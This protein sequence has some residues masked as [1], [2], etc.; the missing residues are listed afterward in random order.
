MLADL[1][2]GVA[3]AGGNAVAPRGPAERDGV[4]GGVAGGLGGLGAGEPACLQDGGGDG[5]VPKLAFA[6]QGEPDRAGELCPSLAGRIEDDHAG[7]LLGG[8]VHEIPRHEAVAEVGLGVLND[9][10]A[11]D[12]EPEED[13][14]GV[15]GQH[16]LDRRPCVRVGL[17]DDVVERV[18]LHAVLL[19]LGEGPSGADA[20]ELLGIAYE[21]ESGAVGLGAREQPL[22]VAR[23]GQRGLIDDLDGVAVGPVLGILDE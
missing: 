23:R 9:G 17:A 8:E 5:L 1:I 4:A 14:S 21:D 22:H 18:R 15:A 13:L 11:P 16:H 3:G 19:K 6:D 12:V 2:D 10:T 20:A 7:A